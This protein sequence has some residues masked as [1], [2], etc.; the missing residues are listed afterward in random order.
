MTMP[1]NLKERTK[2]IWVEWGRA[3]EYGR[4]KSA[5]GIILEVRPGDDAEKLRK[6][7]L[8]YLQGIVDKDL[9]E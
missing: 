3:L 2:R 7:A 6:Q 4:A 5:H 8:A 9:E 1:K